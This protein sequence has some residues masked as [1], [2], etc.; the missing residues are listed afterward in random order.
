MGAAPDASSGVHAGHLSAW[1]RFVGPIL[2]DGQSFVDSASWESET[3]T[4]CFSAGQRKPGRARSNSTSGKRILSISRTNEMAVL[5]GP[6]NISHTF[7]T[8]TL[9]SAPISGGTRHDLLDGVIAADWIPDSNNLAVIRDPGTGRPWTVEFPAGTTVHEAQAAWSLRVSGRKPHCVS[10]GTRTLRRCTNATSWSIVRVRKRS[11]PGTGP[12]SAW[13]G[14]LR[15]V[16]SG[17]RERASMKRARQARTS[18]DT[19]ALIAGRVT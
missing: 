8:R 11:S 5:F 14:R 2:T 6:Q 13:R 1:R 12:R 17:S 15:V 19:P 3:C 7:G 18:V 4:A 16:K 10:R 9:A